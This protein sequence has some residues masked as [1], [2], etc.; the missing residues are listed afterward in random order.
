MANF[1]F[2]RF[3]SVARFYYPRLKYQIIWYPILS[4][5]MGIGTLLCVIANMT[6]LF[7][8]LLVGS[9]F[10]ISLLLEY[11]PLAFAIHS[12]PEI[13]TSLPVTSCEKIA[14]IFLYT[15]IGI[16]VMVL[17]PL[18]LISLAIPES[19]IPADMAEMGKIVSAMPCQ[20]IILSFFQYL[21]PMSICLYAVM[22]YSRKRFAHGII[23]TIC[24]NAVLALGGF[25]VGGAAAFL[26]GVNDG[27]K[28]IGPQTDT[29]ASEIIG[30]IGTLMNWFGSI[31][32][33]CSIFVIYKTYRAIKFHQL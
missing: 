7:I 17:L 3:V 31:L 13:E 6:G 26:A 9:V 12:S 8:L 22:R 11:G 4:V 24:A 33:I 1:S 29:V 25:I 2:N 30:E 16:P 19:M 14:F 20:A 15:F 27:L 28:G 18:S 5:L 23:W 10:L 32:A 21:F